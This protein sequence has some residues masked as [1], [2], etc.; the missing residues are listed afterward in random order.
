MMHIEILETG[1]RRRLER[2]VWITANRN[3]PIVTPHRCKA[4]GIGDGESIWS[5]GGLEG[6]PEA[7]IITRAEYEQ[8]LRAP[9]EDPELTDSEL[10]EIIIKGEMGG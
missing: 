5:L 4:R 7:R 2:E 8:T 6:Y 1:E 3:G 10:L 9:E